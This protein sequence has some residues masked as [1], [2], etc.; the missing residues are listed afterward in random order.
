MLQHGLI[1]QED[2]IICGPVNLNSRLRRRDV[3]FLVDDLS[4]H[5]SR[6]RS[7]STQCLCRPQDVVATTDT[8]VKYGIQLNDL[9]RLI[10]APLW[11]GDGSSRAQSRVL[12][13][14]RAT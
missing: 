11:L 8:T 13:C 5:P 6:R 10:T 2:Q 7:R 14:R 3:S 1:L 12:L 9:R 4:I